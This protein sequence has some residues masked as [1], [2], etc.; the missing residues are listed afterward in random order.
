MEVDPNYPLGQLFPTIAA[1]SC[2]P[3]SEAD[4]ATRWRHRAGRGRD[5]PEAAKG[6]TIKEGIAR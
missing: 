5:E 4:R 3:I 2:I 6:P 1:A